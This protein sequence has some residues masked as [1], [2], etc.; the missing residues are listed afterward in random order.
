MFTRTK[1]IFL[2]CFLVT[3]LGARQL[4]EAQEGA[5][6]NILTLSTLDLDSYPNAVCND[7]SPAGYYYRDNPRSDK[8]LINLQ[9]GG[10]C[11]SAAECSLR[12]SEKFDRI[13]ST[14]WGERYRV[15]GGIM[16]GRA[17]YNPLYHDWDILFAGYCSSDLWA[18]DKQGSD[19]PLEDGDW[20]FRGATSLQA[21][22]DN[23]LQT[24][25]ADNEYDE[26]VLAGW[27]AGGAGAMM[28][29]NR[30]QDVLPPSVTD[31]Y[32]LAD[33]GWWVYTDLFD[34]ELSLPAMATADSIA[35]FWQIN[36][37]PDCVA[38][39]A[40][41]GGCLFGNIA[42]QYVRSDIPTMIVMNKMDE[43]LESRWEIAPPY[44]R[45]DI[46]RLWE[47]AQ[48]VSSEGA[49]IYQETDNFSF[50]FPCRGP[51]GG[52]SR[53]LYTRQQE[54]TDFKLYPSDESPYKGIMTWLDGGSKFSDEF[55][56]TPLTVD[57]QSIAATNDASRYAWFAL[58]LMATPLALLGWRRTRRR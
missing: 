21:Q 7:G 28:Q 6:G 14:T 46:V 36:V 3:L 44:S 30:V 24:H 13:S 20:H 58:L 53:H 55:C 34:S 42:Y 29:S 33:G 37:M 39:E 4:V 51:F 43:A 22:V 47:I 2:A 48:V 49:R 31:Y 12:E 57:M 11:G 50:Y 38:Q 52:L 32:V 15:D 25:F 16:D 18:G 10:F 27:S 1:L 45:A 41:L 54:F 19:N 26:V 40:N 56:S 5:N 17:E 35:N 23:A 9:G 8:L